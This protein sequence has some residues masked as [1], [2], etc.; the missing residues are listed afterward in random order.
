MNDVKQLNNKIDISVVTISTEGD[1]HFASYLEALPSGC[2]CIILFNKKANDI[3]DVGLCK[4]RTEKLNG[5]NYI[6][7]YDYYYD[8]FRFDELRNKAKEFATRKWI[9]SLDTD[10]RIQLLKNDINSIINSPN[11]IGGYFCNV[12]SLKLAKGKKDIESMSQLR[13]FRNDKRFKWSKRAHEQIIDSIETNGFIC[14]YTPINIRHEGYIKY[15]AETMIPKHLRNLNL[16]F[17]DLSEN[18]NDKLGLF[19][20]HNSTNVLA[21]LGY[22]NDVDYK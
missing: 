17:K 19:Q 12:I 18:M 1:P 13:I 15:D 2:E 5:S 11:N 10:E 3:K 4:L 8:E 14:A 16:G 9:V 7:I 20:I 6:K 21:N 22:F